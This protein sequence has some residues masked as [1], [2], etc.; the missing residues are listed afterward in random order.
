MEKCKDCKW[1]HTDNREHT[2]SADCYALPPTVLDNVTT[3]GNTFSYKR[4][5]TEPNE[6]C[7]LF[8]YM[9]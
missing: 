1:W 3:A 5:R 7:S 9:E 8:E 4:P 2:S 6:Y